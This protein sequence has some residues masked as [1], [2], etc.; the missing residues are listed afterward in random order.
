MKGTFVLS[1]ESPSS[2]RKAGRPRT[3]AD[4]DVFNAITVVLSTA[5]Y[6]KLT[7]ALVAEAVGCTTSAL[8]RRYGGKQELLL[9]YLDWLDLNIERNF[10]LYRRGYSSPMAVLRALMFIQ[11]DHPPLEP[12][13]PPISDAATY[14]SFFVAARSEPAYLPTIARMVRRFEQLVASLIDDA[15]EAGELRPCDASRLAHLVTITFIGAVTWWFDA[16]EGLLENE[17][18]RAFDTALEPYLPR[19]Q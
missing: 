19:H 15:Q 8:I 4:A 7:F 13:E 10:H 3:F 2:P 9:A 6:S 17:I 14:M 16:E 11:A 5:G 1:A 12:L 18:A